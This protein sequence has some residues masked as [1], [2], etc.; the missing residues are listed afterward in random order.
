MPVLRE[1]AEETTEVIRVR[2]SK[3][4]ATELDAVQA[5]AKK[6]GREFPLS[7]IVSKAL[8]RAVKQAR[9]ELAPTSGK[10]TQ[11]DADA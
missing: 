1:K 4:L 11:P 7:D 10:P 5:Q 6:Q 8:R 9:A 2:I 3:D